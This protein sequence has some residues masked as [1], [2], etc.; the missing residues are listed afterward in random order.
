MRS[1]A[2]GNKSVRRRSLDVGLVIEEDDLS[3][4]AV[5]RLLD[6]HLQ[7]M[8]ELTPPGSVHALDPDEL[9]AQDITFW[10][11]REAGELVGCAGLKA[12]GAATGEI[13][14]MHTATGHRRRGIASLL[15]DHV[16][17]E[18]RGRE[19]HSVFLETG[20]T[21]LFAAARG[22]YERHGFQRCGPFG[23]YKKDAHSVF[24]RKR[25]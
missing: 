12:L 11:A 24:M 19:Y 21:P 8:V 5:I 25:L 14:S 6:E 13:K 15:L 10:S 1:T 22:L 20:S 17:D 7:E 23:S 4:E 18:A 9:R 16:M 2:V 3:S